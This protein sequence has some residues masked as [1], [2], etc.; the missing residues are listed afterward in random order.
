VAPEGSSAK[1]TVAESLVHDELLDPRHLRPGLRH[2]VLLTERRRH[3]CV[4]SKR[5]SSTAPT[6]AR[7]GN[8]SR[9]A[10]RVALRDSSSSR[11]RGDP[12]A[13]RRLNATVPSSMSPLP[14]AGGH[15]ATVTPAIRSWE[16]CRSWTA[17]VGTVVSRLPLTTGSSEPARRLGPTAGVI[18]SAGTD[19]PVPRDQQ[20]VLGHRDHTRRVDREALPGADERFGG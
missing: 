16:S 12:A 3:C 4:G 13:A 2:R 18:V 15:Q 20:A 7:R 19:T 10:P 11:G 14:M 6:N 17:G 5:D 1:L 8:A 9:N